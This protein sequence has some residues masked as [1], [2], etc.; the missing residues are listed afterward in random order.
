VPPGDSPLR[1]ALFP[2]PGPDASPYIELLHAAVADHDVR[3]LGPARLAPGLARPGPDRPDVVHVHWIEY[4]VR[5]QGNGPGAFARAGARTTRLIAGLSRLR[6]GGVG[7]VWTVHNLRPHESSHPRL[8]AAAMRAAARSAH[9]L[10]VHSNHARELVAEVYGHDAK[11]TVV[12]HGNFIGHYPAPRRSRDEARATLAVP[13][14]A[15]TFLLFGQVR[16]YKRVPEAIAAFRS[17][18]GD[19]LALVVAGSAWDPTERAAVEQAAADDPRVILRLGFVPDE[20]ISELHLAADAAVL[21]YQDLFSSGALLLALSLGVPTVVPAYGSALE[22]A[23]P[24]AVEL[25]GDDCTLAE[26]LEAMTTGDQAARRAAARTAAEA[27]DWQSI[28]RRTAAIYR[29]SATE[30]AK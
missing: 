14:D 12:P 23:T 15:F 16:R 20:E 1:L 6:R 26:A 3:L 5:A 25:F 7:I 22:V 2:A 17:L 21:G 8:E 19:H 9:R 18:R 30:A 10:I 29:E 24:P 13:S 11:V 28:G 4:L 27:A